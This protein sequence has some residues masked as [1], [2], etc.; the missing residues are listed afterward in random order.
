M[1]TI[2]KLNFSALKTFDWMQAPEK[3]AVTSL[4]VQRVKNA[5]NAELKVKGLMMTSDKPDFLIA[6][7]HGKKSIA[8]Y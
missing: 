8:T 4:V 7:H 2:V 5:V 3:A 1:I 6:E